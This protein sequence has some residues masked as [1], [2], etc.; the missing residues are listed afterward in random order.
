MSFAITAMKKKE[1]QRTMR[2]EEKRGKEHTPG[3]LTHGKCLSVFRGLYSRPLTVE[4][5]TSLY[6][7]CSL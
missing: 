6:E 4:G 1:T 7:S 3:Y 2:Q 5:K